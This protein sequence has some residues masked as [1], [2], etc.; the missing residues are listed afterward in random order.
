MKRGTICGLIAVIAVAGAAW[1]ANHVVTISW[2]GPGTPVTVNPDPVVVQNGDTVE[3]RLSE[4]SW[5]GG[6]CAV[7]AGPPLNWNLG[8]LYPGYPG[9]KSP[10]I[11]V[12]PGEYEYQIEC[13]EALLSQADQDASQDGVDSS[14]DQLQTLYTGTVVVTEA[15]PAS[16]TI[17][18]VLLFIV[19]SSVALLFIFMRARSRWTHSR[20]L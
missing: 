7:T 5:P 6:V 4:G 13:G 2:Q 12:P 14:Q 16:T 19:L 1:A 3:F 15:A 20:N 10:P 17:T 8:P 9:V 11:D 18:L